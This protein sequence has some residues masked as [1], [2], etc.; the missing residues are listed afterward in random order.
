MNIQLSNIK[1]T[2]FA[3][4]NLSTLAD[5]IKEMAKSATA[6]APLE[7]EVVLDDNRFN[8]SAPFVLSAEETP[9]L[10]NV[11][12]TIRGAESKKPL[13]CAQR[14]FYND[15]FEAVEGK[16]YF[17]YQ[18]PQ[19]EDGTYPIF[20]EMYVD[21]VRVPMSKSEEM[22]YPFLVPKVL[23]KEEDCHE[24]LFLPKEVVERFVSE[25]IETTELQFN[26]EW[27]HKI[28]RIIGVDFSQTREEGGKTYVLVKMGDE[29]RTF[30]G[31]R[32]AY[33]TTKGRKCAIWNSRVFLTPGSFTYNYKTGVL[34]FYPAEGFDIFHH[35]HEYPI[36]NN[37][38]IFEGLEGLT[39]ENLSFKGITTSHAS[40]NG[41][42]AGQSGVVGGY[43]T[44][45]S[46]ITD[47]AVYTRNMKHFTVKDC[48]FA[49]LG[50]YGILMLDRSV[51]VRIE[52][53][54]F[55][56]IGMS[57]ICVGNPVSSIATSWPNPENQTIN[58]VVTNNYMRHIGYE[59]PTSCAFYVALV[60]VLEFTHNTVIDVPYS[61]LSA[62]WN[63]RQ[64][65]YFL[66]E[67]V[68][69][70]DAEIAYN[71]FEDYMMVL[72]D[73]GATYVNGGNCNPEDATLI[74]CI[75][76]N[77]SVCHSMRSRARY[78]YYMDGAASNWDCYHN[79]MINA[80]LPIFVQPHPQALSCHCHVRDTYSNTPY[81]WYFGE[82]TACTSRDVVVKGFYMDGKTEEE[83][84][85]IYP[86]VRS[87]KE[88]AGCKL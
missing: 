59:F 4:Q 56:N 17:K 5:E 69:V 74:N 76:D 71:Y 27:E 51:G 44:Y 75:H 48:A 20:R 24:G 11:R 18:L 77:Y 23:E 80:N 10:A 73:G 37:L 60:D 41:Y 32:A 2:G 25:D 58:L 15:K 87:I 78:G 35:T 22:V 14:Y 30:A 49:Q 28:F 63:W 36:L 67:S 16:P 68:N 62:G 7:L 33:L 31:R 64:V 81:E 45:R 70:R 43:K 88:N 42:L 47:A 34:Y 84:L 1:K 54:Y 85:E 21:G 26:L 9:E 3:P 50:A 79:V 83:M 29:F 6:A 39:L 82:K 13:I 65:P 38:F 8:L 61:V 52:G 57:A 12:L 19:S 66:G 46:R 72:E 40:E 86:D 53:C 55:D